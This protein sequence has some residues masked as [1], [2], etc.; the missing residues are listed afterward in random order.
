MYVKPKDNSKARYVIQDHH[1]KRRHWDLRLE[2][3]LSDGS[4]TFRSWA[5][6]KATFPDDR[7][8][9]AIPVDDH[10]EHCAYFEGT[11]P[12]GTYG[13]GDVNIHMKGEYIVLESS[14]RKISFQLDNGDKFLLHTM[15]DGKWLWRKN[16]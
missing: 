15:S 16:E 4:T 11:Y 14:E 2:W 8:R 9:L 13:A 7:P 3:P 1:S 5:V 12:A 10:S 6:P